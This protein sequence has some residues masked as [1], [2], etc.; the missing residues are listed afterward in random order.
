MT[1]KKY[2]GEY[3]RY[4]E[5]AYTVSCTHKYNVIGNTFTLILDP[6][7]THM[8]RDKA[9]HSFD[10]QPYQDK[11][12]YYVPCDSSNFKLTFRIK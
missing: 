4:I 8:D 5:T 6:G 11:T 2:E 12:L 3:K 9:L 10:G 1:G 7:S